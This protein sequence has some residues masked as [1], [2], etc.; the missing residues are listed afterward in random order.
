ML[1]RALSVLVLASLGCSSSHGGQASGDDAADHRDAAAAGDGAL[2]LDAPTSSSCGTGTGSGWT[3]TTAS[4]S[5]GVLDFF[6]V[7]GS[8]PSDV[9]A[10]GYDAENTGYIWHTTDCGQTWTSHTNLAATYVGVWGTSANNVYVVG[11]SGSGGVLERS[12][13]GGSSWTPLP[14]DGSTG[15]TSIWGSGPDDIY[16]VGSGPYYVQHSTDGAATW[17]DVP[18][19]VPL[20]YASM[21]WGTGSNDVYIGGAIPPDAQGV[22]YHTTNGGTTLTELDDSSYEASPHGLWSGSGELFATGAGGLLRS[23]TGGT[24]WD[25]TITTQELEA[26]WGSSASDLYAGGVLTLAHST[27]DGVTLTPVTGPTITSQ[28]LALWGPAQPTPATT[29][30]AACDNQIWRGP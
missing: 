15:F 1:A 6:D 9:Y 7:W 14:I 17:H 4:I 12:V 2:A 18:P 25:L 19:P 3:N 29:V 30:W 24:S 26:V 27:D 22:L 16:V 21:V 13:D 28:C 8:G 23:T 5:T 10:V 11:T 20:D